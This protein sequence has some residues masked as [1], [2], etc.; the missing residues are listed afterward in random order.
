MKLAQLYEIHY[1]TG[2]S[3]RERERLISDIKNFAAEQDEYFDIVPFDEQQRTSIT[4][5]G[6]QYYRMEEFLREKFGAPN[7]VNCYRSGHFYRKA[8]SEWTVKDSKILLNYGYGDTI[9]DI[10]RAKVN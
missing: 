8:C 3:Q 9:I 5:S 2:L 10:S 4:I 1:G 7:M 6:T